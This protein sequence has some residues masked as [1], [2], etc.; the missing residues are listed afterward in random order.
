[1]SETNTPPKWDFQ[2][3]QALVDGGIEERYDL[4]FKGA[5]ALD[6]RKP[7]WQTEITKDVSAMA[8]SAGGTIIYGIAEKDSP[9]SAAYAD[10]L[11]PVDRSVF[12][13]DT[14][15]QVIQSIQPKIY[16]VRI[17]SVGV[18]NEQGKAFYIVT[19]PQSTTAHQARDKRYHQRQ[20]T[21]T[22]FMEDYQV[23]D[24]MNRAKFPRVKV[25]FVFETSPNSIGLAICVYNEGKVTANHV[26]VFI[27]LP[28]CLGLKIQERVGHLHMDVKTMTQEY[29]WKNLHYDFVGKSLASDATHSGWAGTKPREDCY[30][31]RDSPI[32]PNMN[33]TSSHALGLTPQNID[34]LRGKQITWEAYADNAPVKSGALDLDKVHE[35][36]SKYYTNRK[37]ENAQKEDDPVQ[38]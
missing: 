16:G 9:G 19:I 6:R 8:N 17:T 36:L 21:T 29:C 5:G 22:A 33:L 20:N 2:R 26:R 4:E 13:S 30:V 10:K 3:I 27:R 31:T 7:E 14:L 32:L 1:M 35:D 37:Q 15:D 12:S 23:R 11:D 34:Q 25:S 18:P 28:L 24:V 38:Q